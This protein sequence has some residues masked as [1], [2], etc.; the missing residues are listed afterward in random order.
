MDGGTGLVDHCV[1]EESILVMKGEKEK[2]NTKRD[3][4]IRGW[5]EWN[6]M[7]RCAIVSLVV[8]D[9]CC[10]ESE[11]CWIWVSL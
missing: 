2:S 9:H 6:G 11:M 8:S 1:T 4:V 10:N 5:C 7:E 3:I